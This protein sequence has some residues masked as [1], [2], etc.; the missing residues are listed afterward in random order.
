M[1]QV[2]AHTK[3]ERLELRVAAA[4]SVVNLTNIDRVESILSGMYEICY[5]VWLEAAQVVLGD[6]LPCEFSYTNIWGLTRCAKGEA[7][8]EDAN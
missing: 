7:K 5:A 6:G 4:S 1:E 8:R 3:Q 2:Y